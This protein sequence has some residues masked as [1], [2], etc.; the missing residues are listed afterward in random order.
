[1]A[2]LEATV[3][4]AGAG[5]VCLFSSADEYEDA[6]ISERRAQGRYGR[7]GLGP[8]GLLVGLVLIAVG[9][10]LVLV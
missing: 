1:M 2:A 9:V 4:S 3:A 5:F 10:A 7:P 8:A 6:L